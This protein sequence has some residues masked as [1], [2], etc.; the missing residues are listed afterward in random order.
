M[1]TSGTANRAADIDL[2]QLGRELAAAMPR[3]GEMEQRVAVEL[4]RLLAEGEPVSPRRLA[5]R[6]GLSTD[7]ADRLLHAWPGVFTDRDGAVIA[8]WGLALPEMPHRFEV[9]G[10][11]LH[12][13]CAWDSLF[14]PEILGK[15]AHV[16]SEC[17]I[18]GA[19]ISL[20][21][22]PDRVREVSPEGAVLS[23]VR[24]D[25]P[26][27]A[28]MIQSFCH[29]VLFFASEEAGREWTS[30]RDNTFLLTIEDGFEL[31]RLTNRAKFG[32]ALSDDSSGS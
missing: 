29:Y 26:F 31:G 25:R 11:R 18:T 19:T 28:G 17:P 27:D 10:K 14:I 21:V 5:E 3:L 2:G 8:F 20:A 22:E 16:E 4:Y 9:D 30:G 7:A 24:P 15:T 32:A 1:G 6:C 13:W 23:F 12:T